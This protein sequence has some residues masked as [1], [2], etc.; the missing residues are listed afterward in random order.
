MKIADSFQARIAT[1]LI[2]LLL[3][4][5]GSLY[6]AVQV[7][8]GAA[9]K[10]QAVAQLQRLQRALPADDAVRASFFERLNSLAREHKRKRNFIQLVDS[11]FPSSSS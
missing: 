4:V 2:L 10:Q 11:H 9:V 1:V 3:L 6:F 5:V 7:A 8:T